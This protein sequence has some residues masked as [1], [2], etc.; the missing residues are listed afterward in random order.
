[1]F[2]ASRFCAGLILWA[3]LLLPT[4]A[5]A[6]EEI[7]LYDSDIVVQ[8]SGRLIVEETIRV[9]AEGRQIRR[10]IF[11]DFPRRIPIENG[12]W[13]YVGFKIL[14]IRRNGGEEPY[15]TENVGD[16]VRIYIGDAD[17]FIP[18]GEHTFTIRYETTRQLRYFEDFDELFWN[19]TGNFWS[20]PIRQ[21]VAR[22]TIP[23]GAA[24]QMRAAYTGSYGSKGTA[25]EI[26]SEVGNQITFA[27]TQTLRPE[28]G[29]TVAVGWPKGF[30]SEPGRLSELWFKLW[31]NL[32]L[33]L[34]FLGTPAII[35]Y[36]FRTWRRVGRDPERGLIIPLFRPPEKLSPAA[37]SYVYYR[38]FDSQGRGATKPFIAA[39]LSLA[40]KGYMRIVDE[41]GIFAVESTDQTPTPLPGGEKAIYSGLVG[42]YGRTEF[43]KS[44]GVRIKTTQSKFSSA[45][46]NE[47]EGVFFKMNILYFV[48]GAALSVALLFAY[49]V[50]QQ[51]YGDIAGYAFIALA[52]SIVGGLFLFLGL[53]RVLGWL[54]GDPSKLLGGIFL[55]IGSVLLL[56]AL[57]TPFSVS[58]LISALVPIAVGLLGFLT[59]TFFFLLRAPTPGGRDIMDKIEGFR[60]YLSVAEAERMNM[61]DAPDVTREIYE[62]YLPYAIGLGVEKPWSAAFASHLARSAPDEHDS[63]SYNPS[64][65]GGRGWNVDQ[66]GAAT[67][68]LVSSMSTSMASAMPAPKSSS[69][70]SGGGFS[71]GGGGGGGGGGW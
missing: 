52:C 1:M 57:S 20:F 67:S 8:A 36:Y 18:H 26:V 42:R 32:G 61:E 14:D 50:L 46:L 58:N 44:H 4:N 37:A 59:I 38:G 49:L 64:W 24:I 48:L 10:G 40:A 25:Y 70:S 39:M 68:G 34:L 55:I 60:L 53:R 12:L 7:L 51:P 47:Y 63:S 54:P 6:Q 33:V 43:I 28:E 22:V 9:R 65:Y 45:L 35:F 21:A 16:F 31:D 11:R 15:H 29:L 5:Q 41:D 3:T 23:E 17:V 30:V 66:I 71:G 62:A 27:T 2:A 56:V 13:R 69:G 19:V